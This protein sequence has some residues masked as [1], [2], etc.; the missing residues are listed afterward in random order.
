MQVGKRPV[1]F[2]FDE[3]CQEIKDTLVGLS[4]R[5]TRNFMSVLHLFGLA[6]VVDP[7]PVNLF[8]GRDNCFAEHDLTRLVVI[9]G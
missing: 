1:V 4:I 5:I 9:V 6:N 8:Y 2:R 3:P 7:F